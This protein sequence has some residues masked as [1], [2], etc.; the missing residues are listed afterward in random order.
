M[1]AHLLVNLLGRSIEPV[2]KDIALYR[3]AWTEVGHAGRGLVTLVVPTL[4]GEDEALI[5]AA[6][7]ALQGQLRVQTSL[8]REAVWD[9]PAFLDESDASGITP[10][11]FLATR[12]ANQTHELIR[13]AAERYLSTAS[14]IGGQAHC[15][16]LVE[17]LK[18]I[19]V[20][21]VGCHIDMGWPADLA[22]EQL[23]ALNDLRLAFQESEPTNGSLK[24]ARPINGQAGETKG[25]FEASVTK[26]RRSSLN[27]TE[28]KLAEL[29]GGLLDVSEIGPADN[30][31]DL[32]GHSLLAARAVSEIERAFGARLAIKTL[33]VSSLSQLA[34]EIERNAGPRPAAQECENAV[35]DASPARENSKSGLLASWFKNTRNGDR[36]QDGSQPC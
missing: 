28:E 30:F 6:L 21:E 3:R 13:F 5:E 2:A 8:L 14:L 20:D 4:V 16:A 31:F 32:G 33:M 12:S 17:K 34:V 25:R 19:G 36:F 24:P 7:A 1:G 23:E 22:C 10:D 11:E 29:W 15:V 9:F 35:H 26:G 27:E 18:Q